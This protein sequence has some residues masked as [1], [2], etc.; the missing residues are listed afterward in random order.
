MRRVHTPGRHSGK[1]GAH[2]EHCSWR[3][4]RIRAIGDRDPH[5]QACMLLDSSRAVRSV[6]RSLAS[7]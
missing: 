4:R 7:P 1:G 5:A 3:C 2:S 6:Q